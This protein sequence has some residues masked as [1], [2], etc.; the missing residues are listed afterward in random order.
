MHFYSIL[1]GTL[2][3]A[4][5]SDEYVKRILINN[6]RIE[7]I[8]LAPTRLEGQNIIDAEHSGLAWTQDLFRVQNYGYVH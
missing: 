3:T 4:K 8:F 2:T 6:H 5:I 1:N 7:R